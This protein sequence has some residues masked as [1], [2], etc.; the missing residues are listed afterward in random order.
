MA[1]INSYPIFETN[2]VLND[3]HLNELRKY[4]DEQNRLTRSKLIGIGIVCGFDMSVNNKNH[5]TISSGCG[6]TSEG[7]LACLEKKVTFTHYNDYENPSGY[8][9]FSEI[10]VLELLT[11]SKD[12]ATTLSTGAFLNDKVVVALVECVDN[13]ADTCSTQ[14]CD[15][16][17]TWRDF[18]LRFLLITEKAALSIQKKVNKELSD[19]DTPKDIANILN[20]KYLLDD[21]A[22]KRVSCLG[23]NG[24]GSLDRFEDLALLYIKAISG[25]VE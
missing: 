21:L 3:R 20:K 24:I 23:K 1:N 25:V 22:I 18:H 6:I 8:H 16:H 14:D 13:K 7:F 15:E 11:K 12:N 5:I 19:V 17:G 9:L 2:Q 4:L 10:K